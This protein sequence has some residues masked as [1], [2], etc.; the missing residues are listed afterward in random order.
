[1]TLFKDCSQNF[2]LSINMALVNRGFLHNTNMEKFL[3]NNLLWNRWSDFEII[4]QKHSLRDLSKRLLAKFWFVM[5]HGSSECGLL[6]LYGHE[7]ILLSVIK[8]SIG[9][10]DYLHR[11]YIKKF[12]LIL[13]WKRPKKKKNVYGSHKDWVE[14]SRAILALF[15]K[16]RTYTVELRYNAVLGGP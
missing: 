2:D 3:K 4:S 1:M 13:L 15:F 5:K 6:S 9:E 10:W 7:Q 16:K 14:W 11:M 12:L 8:H